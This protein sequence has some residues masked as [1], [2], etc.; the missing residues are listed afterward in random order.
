M[1]SESHAPTLVQTPAG[2]FVGADLDLTQL[3]LPLIAADRYQERELLGRGGMGEVRLVLDKIIGREVALKVMRGQPDSDLVARFLREARVQG[4]LEHPAIVP[5]HEL[6]ADG[7][8]GLYFTMKRVRGRTLAELIT[9]GDVGRRRLLSAFSTACLAVHF[10]HAR[11]VLHR[12]LKPQNLM[13]GDFGEVYVLDWGLAK[14]TGATLAESNP[15][16]AGGDSPPPLPEMSNTARGAVMGTPGYAPPEQMRG[17]ALTVAADIYSLGAI[18]FE[19]LT[20]E[21]LH[22]GDNV[23]ALMQSTFR[24]AEVAGRMGD[25]P[26]ELET[27]CARATATDPAARYPSARELSQ[28]VEQYLDGEHDLERRRALAARHAEAARAALADAPDDTATRGRAMREVASALGLDPQNGDAVRTLVQLL[29]EPPRELPPEALAEMAES[30]RRTQITGTR[31][32]VAAYVAMLVFLPLIFWMGVHDWLWVAI[33]LA[34]FGLA[35]LAS[36]VALRRARLD[37]RAPLFNIIVSQTAMASASLVFGPFIIVPMAVLAN[38]AAFI[39]STDRR[40]RGVLIVASALAVVLPFFLEW[41]GILPQSYLFRGGEL[42][43]QPVAV[44][45]PR[46]ATTVYLLLANIIGVVM[47]SAFLGRMRDSQLEAERRLY[48]HSWQLKQIV[49]EASRAVVT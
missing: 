39:A 16:M 28:A 23:N 32:S 6:A 49:P 8:G 45:M 24:G 11:G 46:T 3:P 27:I 29:T 18:L 4:Q 30:R 5:V 47:I 2:A 14:L 44:W 22:R 19:L 43:V 13:M 40:R 15:P 35:G 17:G 48:L 34:C 31:A 9:A 42:V 12:D 21:R 25:T 41:C 10:A 1:S 7:A 26:P 20:R 33:N 36:V 37:G 38:T